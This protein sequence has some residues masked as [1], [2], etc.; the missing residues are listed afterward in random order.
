MFKNMTIGKKLGLGFSMVLLLLILVGV[1]S[2]YG[3][4]GMSENATDVVAQIHPRAGRTLPG[5]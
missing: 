4:T 3:I 1:I 2:F 5:P